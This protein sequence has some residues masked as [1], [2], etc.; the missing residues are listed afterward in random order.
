MNEVM[1]AFYWFILPAFVIL[2]AVVTFLRYRR[3]MLSIDKKDFIIKAMKLTDRVSFT[4]SK[5]FAITPHCKGYRLA[6][7]HIAYNDGCCDSHYTGHKRIQICLC[8]DC[9][10]IKE[11]GQK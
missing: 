1:Q 10:H 2:L 6:E 11:L 8:P 9:Y 4:V 5:K 7:V 3:V